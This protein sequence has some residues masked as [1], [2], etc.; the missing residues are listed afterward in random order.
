MAKRKSRKSNQTAIIIIAVLLILVLVALTIVLYKTGKLDSIIDAILGETQDDNLDD[1]NGNNGGAGGGTS[2]TV[3]GDSVGEIDGVPIKIH[4]VFVGQGDGIVIE[5]PENKYML[6]DAGSGLSASSA[7]KTR[8]YSYLSDVVE[9]DVIDYLVV[10]HPDSDHVNMMSQVVDDYVIKNFYFNDYYEDGSA[11]YRKFTDKAKAEDGA[12]LHI[13]D[14]PESSTFD[15]TVGDCVLTFFSPGN[16]G[17]TKTESKIKNGM[18]IITLL[19]YGGRK[20]LLTGDAPSEEE[21]WFIL[22]SESYDMDVDFLKVAHHGS[23]HS[24]TTEFL[25]YVQAEY[26]IICVDEQDNKY[27]HPTPDALARLEAADASV[28]RTDLNGTIILTIDSDGDFAFS[29]VQ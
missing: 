15:L 23:Q 7:T 2:T 11:T 3:R 22:Y 25:A 4:F 21:E 17:F 8:Y 5:L 13:I 24:S 19:T 6:V 26:A 9:G 16:D 10:T 14:T 29:F 28:Y 12:T 20:L 27:G 18:S 1:G